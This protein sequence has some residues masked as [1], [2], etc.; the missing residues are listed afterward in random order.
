MKIYT[1]FIILLLFPLLIQ[2]QTKTDTLRS[3]TTDLPSIQP[4]QQVQNQGQEVQLRMQEDKPWLDFDDSMPSV[5]RDEE[6]APKTAK[7]IYTLHPYNTTTPF[8]WDPIYHRK[9]AINADTWRGA[10]W[11]MLG[12]SDIKGMT[13]DGHI[14]L[15][16]DDDK[17]VRF[18]NGMLVGDYATL[19]TQYFT[20]EFWRFRHK[21]NQKET[22]EVLR[23]YNKVE[24]LTPK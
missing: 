7:N 13:T 14:K 18:E 6:A 12:V 10:Y 20:R 24:G 23:E 15:E 19:L 1:L 8:D 5:F 11:K 16:K 17:L 21:K 9:I 22:K 3:K 2:A 4:I